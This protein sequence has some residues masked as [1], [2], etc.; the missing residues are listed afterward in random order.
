MPW[1]RTA[2][3]TPGEARR[4][5]VENLLSV[6]VAW[7]GLTAVA[8]AAHIHCCV[9]PGANIGVAIG[10]PSFPAT[11]SGSYLH[12]FDLLDPSVY[13]ASFLVNFGGGTAAGARDAV[14]AGLETGRAHVNIHNAVFPGGEIR[15]NAVS[16]P[17]S[18][19][20]LATALVTT[21]ASRRVRAG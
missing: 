1:P 7:S 16:E 6:D 19:T 2:T 13:T 12:D 8:T 9:D 5:A 15:G 21:A 3:T 4:T 20:L 17:S 14:L 18:L 10:F 11:T